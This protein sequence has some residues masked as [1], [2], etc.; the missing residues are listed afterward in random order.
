MTFWPPLHRL[1]RF[2]PPRLLAA[3]MELLVQKAILETPDLK[4]FKDHKV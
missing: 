4:V 2:D 3:Q 1:F